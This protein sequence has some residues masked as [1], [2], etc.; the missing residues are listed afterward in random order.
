[1]F[2]TMIFLLTLAG[3]ERSMTCVTADGGRI[4]LYPGSSFDVGG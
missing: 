4:G 1:M 2:L 3:L